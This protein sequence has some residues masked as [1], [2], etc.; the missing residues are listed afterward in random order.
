MNLRYRK[1][2]RIWNQLIL[3]SDVEMSSDEDTHF[4]HEI[5]S[6]DEMAN[7]QP[8]SLS[9]TEWQALKIISLFKRHNFYHFSL[10]ILQTMKSVFPSSECVA[11]LN[12]DYIY[13]FVDIHPMKEVHYCEICNGVFPDNL[14]DFRCR[15]ENCEGFRYKGGFSH[16]HKKDRQP[17]K[18]ILKEIEKCKEE[19]EDRK[20]CRN[21][22]DIT[23]GQAYREILNEDNSF[24]QSPYNLSAIINTD[25][26]NLYFSS[27][28]E[29]WPIFMAINELSP[30][31][32]FSRDNMLLVGI[33]QGKGK[34]PFKQYIESFSEEMNSLYNEGVEVNTDN[35]VIAVK[36]GVI[37]GVFDL[38]AKAGILNMT[39]FNGTEACITCEEPGVVV[40]Q[41]KGSSRCYRNVAE[42]YPLRNSPEVLENMRNATDKK[43]IKGF[44]GIFGLAF[45]QSF[46]LVKGVVPDYMHCILLGITKTLLLKWFSPTQSGKNYFIGKHIKT[47]SKRLQNIQPPTS[48]ER[49]PRDLEKHVNNLKATELQACLLYYGLPCLQEILPE[50]FLVHF[51]YQSEAV[52][53][54]LGDNIL[55]GQWDR[56]AML[57]DKFYYSFADL[58]GQGS[59]GLNVHN[60]CMHLVWYVKL[61]GPLW[62]W[63]CFPFEDNNAMLL[64]AVHGTG[65]VMRQVMLYKQA[66]SCLRRKGVQSAQ[67]TLWKKTAE[68]ANCDISGK[69][70]HLR[71]NELEAE[72]LALLVVEC[73]KEM[74]KVD[75]I[76]IGNKQYCSSQYLRLKKRVYNVVLYSHTKIGY[77]THFI[78]NTKDEKVY[79]VLKKY[80]S[81]K[82][83][84]SQL[85]SGKHMLAVKATQTLDVVP[86]EELIDTL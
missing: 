43:R 53:I 4:S 41:G 16:Q 31:A 59:C 32:G 54:L 46:D 51:S 29:L 33:W 26:V 76:S 40:K 38:P 11:V 48:I 21:L 24:L 36:L 83:K 8:E 23:N 62:A 63:S 58:Y 39:Y 70:K 6:N 69:V 82:T 52:Y 2:H 22:T 60:A 80:E 86:A 74:R 10:D 7:V 78:Y 68:A 44:K 5:D 25:G 15:V 56:A 30:K 57:L 67:S 79:A 3:F 71:D 14:D 35:G 42:Q 64:Q 27:K 73:V 1:P 61:W 85:P 47:I 77:I 12:L 81:A 13:S 72:V 37:C 45:L 18:R 17:R 28:I 65:N 9:E 66:V 49:L 50:V 20:N 19:I 84:L 55:P 75:Q 34:P